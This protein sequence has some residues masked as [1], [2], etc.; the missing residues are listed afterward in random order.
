VGEQIT[1]RVSS[2][3]RKQSKAEEK[4]Y[5]IRGFQAGQSAEKIL[6][7]IRESAV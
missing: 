1:E 3:K 5:D 7:Q 4:V 2:G 6:P